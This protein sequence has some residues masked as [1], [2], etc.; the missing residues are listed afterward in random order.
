[1]SEVKVDTIS[2]RTT[3]AG[4]TVE[5]VKIEDGVATFQTAAGSPLV[6]EGATAD[7]FETTF[8]ITD[9]TADRTITFPDASITLAAGDTNTPAWMVGI[10]SDQAIADAT[11][12]KVALNDVIFE[13]GIT[14]DT[15]NYKG[16][17]GAGKY[18]IGAF[19][20]HDP[21]TGTE[22][23]ATCYAWLKVNGSAVVDLGIQ[24]ID[25]QAK[26]IGKLSVGGSAII[27]L[28]ATDYVE[29]F[30]YLDFTS[31]AATML[32]YDAT[33]RMTY[34]YGMKVIGA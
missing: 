5:G 21:T 7:A 13:T 23:I 32:R 9:P 16:I 4:V 24:T 19:I 3:D 31:G 29:L 22:A 33:D 1:M 18:L 34:M 2:E 17:P 12:T 27:V 10:S 6:F 30:G 25:A 20:T 26:D 15:T 11:G 14:W 28:G 8:A